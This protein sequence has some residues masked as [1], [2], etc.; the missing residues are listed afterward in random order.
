MEGLA[1]PKLP[2]L[3]GGYLIPVNSLRPAHLMMLGKVY[4]KGLTDRRRLQGA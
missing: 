4:G 2:W 1:D 3:R